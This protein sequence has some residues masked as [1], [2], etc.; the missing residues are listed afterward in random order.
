MTVWEILIL[1]GVGFNTY[2][3][4]KETKFLRG[5]I[6]DQSEFIKDATHIVD[7]YRGPVADHEKIVKL[8][9]ESSETESKKAIEAVEARIREQANKSITVLG[10]E[11]L[12]LITLVVEMLYE[13]AALPSIKQHLDEM[14][15]DAPVKGL[16]L[17]IYEK[18]AA[19]WQE[20]YKQL[21]EKV[22]I[23]KS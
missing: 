15:D 5:K 17:E 19:Q 6:K 9:R 14:S 1:V 10:K 21:E 18:R 3:L 16:L 11:A 13:P 23:K 7:L 12:A 4:L 20:Y 8:M 2:W 22:G